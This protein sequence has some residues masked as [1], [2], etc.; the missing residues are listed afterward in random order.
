MKQQKTGLDF[1]S[2]ASHQLRTPLTLMKGYL[3]M[4]LEGSFGKIKEA[5]LKAALKVVYQA[6]ER[7]LRLA[8]NLLEMARLENGRLALDVRPFAL[9]EVIRGLLDEMKSK[10]AVKG[11]RLAY[12]NSLS[13][14]A[15]N[16]DEVMLRQV[17][18]NVLDNAIKYSS[19]GTIIISSQKVGRLIEIAV[20]DSGPGLSA[21]EIKGIFKKF[22]RG[23]QSRDGNGFGLGLYI[24]RL[25]MKAHGGS[26]SAEPGKKKGL[27]VSLRFPAK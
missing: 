7:L 22:E 20:A 4:I 19:T 6:N 27:R 5:K 8:E 23:S 16:A 26:I 18:S 14:S 10:A 9:N 24:A 15:V 1:I 12:K 3:S 21:Q 11:L 17:I 25:I 2:V 13:K